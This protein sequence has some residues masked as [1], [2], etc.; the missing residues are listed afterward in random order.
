MD[1]LDRRAVVSLLSSYA[2]QFATTAVGLAS[3]IILARLI[4]PDDLGTYSLV[5]M[6][7]MGADMLM[8][9][10]ISQHIV[11]EDHRPYGNFLML[12]LAIA[13]VLFIGMQVFAPVFTFWGPEFPA[14]L[15]VMA[16]IAIIKAFSSVPTLYLDRELLINKSLM[17][18][19]ARLLTIGV[20]SIG[21]AYYGYGV[22]AMAWGTV[23]S[24][25][26]YAIMIWYAARKKMPLELE[27]SNTWHLIKG[28][29]FL[30]LIG[31]MGFA[32][33]QGDV[34][35]IGTLLDSRQVG[36]YAMAYT[37]VIMVSKVVESAI[38]RVIYPTFCMFKDDLEKLGQIYRQATLAITAIEAPIYF[39]LL[40]NAPVVVTMVLGK[41]WEQA[42]YLV[43]AMS[44]F[45]IINPFSTFGNEIL[46]AK[47]K[48]R[49]LTAATV[50][51]AT[52]LIVSGYILTAIYGTVGMV[53][54][55]Y[56]IIG[57]IP[58]IVTVY[59]I[60]KKDFIQ[61]S[62]QLGVIYSASLAIA[63]LVYII[64]RSQPYVQAIL[65]AVIIPLNWYAYYHFYGDGL[66]SKTI[67]ILKAEKNTQAADAGLS[68][69]TP[70]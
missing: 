67:S 34:A 40:F 48:D 27:W 46:R 64:F 24:E 16:V 9:L 42:S 65:G 8:D 22:W 66:G 52:N 60:I 33:Q 56:I 70:G 23:A 17:P 21:L 51:G 3:K 41:K 6:V 68:E 19:I 36:Y 15:R 35:I 2:S 54:A 5:L 28:S 30:F 13:G 26:V 29:K 31:I 49:I 7:L 69:S 50:I 63:W 57:S 59:K 25:T 55:K 14:V 20:I 12:R 62:W 61:L 58:T 18:Q 47:K 39:Y 11:R 1:N 37:L 53:M 4:A 32:L 44:V 38:F 10:G 45:G 43:Q